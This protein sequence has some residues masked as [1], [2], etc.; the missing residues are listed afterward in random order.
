MA[1]SVYKHRQGTASHACPHPV[2]SGWAMFELYVNGRPRTPRG[3]PL[4]AS[5][6]LHVALVVGTAVA[7]LSVVGEPPDVPTMIAF[8]APLSVPPPAPPPAPATPL[9]K[10][11]DTPSPSVRAVSAAAPVEAPPVLAADSGFEGPTASSDSGVEHGVTGGV[12]GGVVGG[13][14]AVALTPPP[15]PAPLPLRS[16]VR[17]G[18]LVSAPRV[19]TRVRPLYPKVAARAH[20]QGV[21]ILEAIVDEDGIVQEIRVLRSVT[22]LD[23]PAIDALKQWRYEPLTLNGNRMPFL[24]TVSMMFSAESTSDR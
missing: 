11:P 21:V 18:G 17:V 4:A 6:A 5:L 13:I 23:E 2:L 1:V 24:L 15:T 20:I 16:P 12:I 7:A 14:E 22:Y 19:L 10:K 9:K 3:T 8:V